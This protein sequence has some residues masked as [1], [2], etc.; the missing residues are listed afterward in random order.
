[1]TC[2][3][4]IFPVVLLVILCACSGCRAESYKRA[5]S[6]T[7]VCELSTHPLVYAEREIALTTTLINSPPHG[8]S[9]YSKKCRVPIAIRFS[10]EFRQLGRQKLEDSLGAYRL[11]HGILRFKISV[12]GHLGK[13]KGNSS[14]ERPRFYFDKVVDLVPDQPPIH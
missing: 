3:A 5:V 2:R 7:D 6:V 10:H 9:F 4:A 13:M 1:M 14:Y 11:D 12:I 8:M